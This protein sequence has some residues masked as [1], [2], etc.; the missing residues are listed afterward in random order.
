M[1]DIHE[2]VD[3]L[4][5]SDCNLYER[6]PELVQRVD[7]FLY[8]WT[9][10]MLARTQALLR[11]HG[12]RLQSK[13]PTSTAQCCYYSNNGEDE[14]FTHARS[15]NVVWR[16]WAVGRLQ[17]PRYPPER[18]N[19]NKDADP[20]FLYALMPALRLEVPWA[21]HRSLLTNTSKN[22]AAST[23]TAAAEATSISTSTSIPTAA[24]AAAAKTAASVPLKPALKRTDLQTFLTSPTLSPVSSPAHSPL[25]SPAMSIRENMSTSSLGSDTTLDNE[26]GL[27]PRLR[28][29]D[30]V[31][32]CMVVF[33]HESECLPAGFEEDGDGDSADENG[34]SR[35]YYTSNS[36]SSSS[37]SVR[38]LHRNSSRNRRTL[39][40]KLAPT[41][42]KGDHRRLV[43]VTASP[44]KP[45]SS[46]HMSYDDSD[47]EDFLGD[48]SS[49]IALFGGPTPSERAVGGRHS[50]ASSSSSGSKGSSA[51][52]KESAGTGGGVSGYV[53][54][55]VQSVAGQVRRFVT[56]A[57]SVSTF[58]AEKPT[59]SPSAPTQQPH[60]SS[61]YSSE[62]NS[63]TAPSSTPTQH[64]PSTSSHVV[65][66]P[67]S[68]AANKPFPAD[69]V[70]FDDDEDAIIQE[71]E[72]EMQKHH[73]RP[74]L[75][76]PSLPKHRFYSDS[77]HSAW[78]TCEYDMDGSEYQIH[79][80][81]EDDEDDG[82][83]STYTTPPVSAD[84]RQPSFATPLSHSQ[85]F[86]AA[87]AGSGSADGALNA[88]A[89]SHSS[90]NHA[91]NESIIDRAEDT[92]VN[93]VDAVKWC[94]SF[95]SNYTI[96]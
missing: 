5:L 77:Y 8:D 39:V 12:K 51:G 72:R 50:S 35:R 10:H 55:Y 37:S 73:Y 53:Q 32:Q 14:S 67:F 27:K 28:F 43:S 54:G 3:V 75:P 2:M 16:Q 31:E 87:A 83:L 21:T 91:R 60:S 34:S 85:A 62:G 45:F 13:T 11:K 25:H 66:D 4:L 44:S 71:F 76:P 17:L 30:R 23:T 1:E 47:D 68:S 82:E 20:V 24:A 84:L 78:S 46:P 36:S 22:A 89:N 48:Y 80:N 69:H 41:P 64:T 18:I 86:G 61:A 63:S 38:R 15:V 58:A 57:V 33:K 56:D 94:A 65:R 52:G 92:I 49:G 6:Y 29:N 7:Y 9:E 70:P 79:R 95:I 96:F 19:W 81:M 90:Q 26:A 59:K 88:N 74:S 42:L 93:T 40:I